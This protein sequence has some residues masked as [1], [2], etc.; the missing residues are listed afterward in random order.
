[1]K[2]RAIDVDQ[3]NKNRFLWLG[4]L[5]DRSPGALTQWTE[6][7]SISDLSAP[8]KSVEQWKRSI[9]QLRYCRRKHQNVTR[10]FPSSLRWSSLF[11]I[12]IIFYLKNQ[13]AIVGRIASFS[14]PSADD[15]FFLRLRPFIFIK[16]LRGGGKCLRAFK[17]TSSGLNWLPR[18][19][20]GGKFERKLRSPKKYW[21]RVSWSWCIKGA[22]L[23]FKHNFLW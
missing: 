7:P 20:N 22:R 17:K 16:K 4:Q 14:L 10:H 1:M 23:T 3:G 13:F 18:F 21:Q 6:E 19:D 5:T 2:I 11:S 12:F 9:N 15:E 8:G